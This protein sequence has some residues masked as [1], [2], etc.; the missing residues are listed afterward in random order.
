MENGLELF[1]QG[2]GAVMFCTAIA[3]MFLLFSQLYTLENAVK[4]NLDEGHIISVTLME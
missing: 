2:M 4:S 3:V 1:Y